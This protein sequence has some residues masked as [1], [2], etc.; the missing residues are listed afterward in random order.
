MRLG[1]GHPFRC[2]ET[3]KRESAPLSVSRLFLLIFFRWIISR[4]LDEFFFTFFFFFFFLFLSFFFFYCFWFFFSFI[5][6]FFCRERCQRWNLVTE[7]GAKFI[8]F[9]WGSHAASER[10]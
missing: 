9:W 4:N 2:L 7:Y 6:L 3:T 5:F 8:Y 1:F 10:V